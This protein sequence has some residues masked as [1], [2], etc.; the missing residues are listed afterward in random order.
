[1][2][3]FTAL[4]DVPRVSL[5]HWPTPLEPLDRLRAAVGGPRVWAKREDCSGLALGGNKVRKLEVHL[6][7]AR[8]RGADTIITSG[9]VQSNHCRQTA[10]AAVR[11]DVEAH[12]VLSELVPR[13]DAAY[14][15]S[16]NRRLDD[17]LGAV[18]HDGGDDPDA[19][20][21]ELSGELEALGRTVLV[22]PA[23]GSDAWGTL[24]WAIGG[25]EMIEQLD[26]IGVTPVEAVVATSTGGTAAGLRL[27]LDLHERDWG[28][29]A[30]D[31]AGLAEHTAA[32][33][34]RLHEEA[35][36]LLGAD[37]ERGRLTVTD[38]HRGPGYGSVTADMVEAVRLLARTEG[39]LLDPVYSGKAAAALVAAIGEGR[40]SD[41]DDVVFLHTGGT[42]ALFAYDDIDW[43]GSG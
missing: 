33:V 42:P 28:L 5:G 32:T 26:A 1:M 24:G 36:Q 21:G 9:A 29:L 22:I 11:S 34:A 37:H 39:L 25:T 16:G 6:G 19:T 41:A 10:A 31:V 8:E 4:R 13:H 40:W 20:A 12:L 7:R 17:V 23:G 38:A 15:G 35:S 27:A 3:A 30:V 18:V 43:S 14:T 2:A